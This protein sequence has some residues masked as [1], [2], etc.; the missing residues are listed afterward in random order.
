MISDGAVNAYNSNSAAI[1]DMQIIEEI[2]KVHIAT[3]RAFVRD[4]D[5]YSKTTFF[6]SEAG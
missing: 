2:C 3:S 6:S 1:S 4:P 5:N